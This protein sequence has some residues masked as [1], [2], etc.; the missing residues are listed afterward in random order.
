MRSG[1]AGG[2]RRSLSASDRA[3]PRGSRPPERAVLLCPTLCQAARKTEPN[4]AQRYSRCAIMRASC[5]TG[6]SASAKSDLSRSALL[7]WKAA[8]MLP[9]P[10]SCHE[11]KRPRIGTLGIVRQGPSIGPCRQSPVAAPP[12]WASLAGTASRRSS[13]DTRV[14]TLSVL[15]HPPPGWRV[16]SIRRRHRHDRHPSRSR[17]S[18]L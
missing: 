9:V 3:D 12:L 15:A 16:S 14:P 6:R 10:L 11:R 1:Y 7:H 18:P 8:P 17:Y 4:R 13:D 2:C 5:S